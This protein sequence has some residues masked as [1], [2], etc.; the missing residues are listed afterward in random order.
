MP[1]KFPI[2][3]AFVLSLKQECSFS[4]SFVSQATYMRSPASSS[5]VSMPMPVRMRVKASFGSS[6]AHSLR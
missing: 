5:S 4:W 1:R 2:R 6:A 3:S